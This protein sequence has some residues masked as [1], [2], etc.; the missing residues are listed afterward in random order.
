[1][2]V[3]NKLSTDFK[4][5][6]GRK[7]LY[8]F[9]PFR[10]PEVDRH[11]ERSLLTEQEKKYPQGLGDIVPAQSSVSLSAILSFHPS[12]SFLFSLMLR[13]GQMWN[14]ERHRDVEK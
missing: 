5:V 3:E 11:V 8:D 1:M 4:I 12:V 10:F 7:K 14:N 13:Q 2:R 9:A 6:K